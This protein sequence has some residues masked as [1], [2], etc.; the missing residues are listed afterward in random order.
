M[1]PGP[2]ADAVTKV[3]AFEAMHHSEGMGT[4]F[5]AISAPEIFGLALLVAGAVLR[6][7]DMPETQGIK[8]STGLYA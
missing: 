5:K 2:V 8:L 7:K 6:V 1:L 3:L 4:G